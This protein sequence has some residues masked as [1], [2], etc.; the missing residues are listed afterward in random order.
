[1]YL[2]LDV[3]G[4]M[5]GDAIEAVRIGMRALL[6]D[7]Q[8]NPQALET[9]WLSVITFGS[10]ARQIVPL[11]EIGSFVEPKLTTEGSTNLADALKLLKDRINAEVR[12]NT[13][14]QKGDW[15]PLIFLM[16]DGQ[17]DSGWEAAADEVKKL[18][19][20][21]LIACAVG[22]A[23]DD[24]VLRRITEIVVRLQDC[25]PGTLG[26]FFQWMTASVTATSVAVETKGEAAI[27]LP[28]LPADK[29][30]VIVP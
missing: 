25:S 14:S 23:A 29:G 18:K 24:K 7:L 5:E 27:D 11:T 4:S 8:G 2:V 30:I 28:A 3:S 13:A 15:K 19:P 16:T 10:S 26:A 12:K 1:V 22:P 17:P 6:D 21:N 9:V 20:G